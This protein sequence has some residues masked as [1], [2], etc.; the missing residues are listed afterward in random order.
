MKPVDLVVDVEARLP[1]RVIALLSKLAAAAIL[2]TA[3]VIAASPASAETRIV[4]IQQMSTDRYVDAH[5]HAGEDYR[6]VTREAQ[7]NDTQLW[8]M[9][10]LDGNVFTI[11]QLSSGRYWDAHEYDGQDYR[12]VTRPAQNNDTQRWLALDLGADIFTIQ[13]VSN[14]RYV[15]AH[16]NTA[17]DYRL[18]TR[19]AQ[20]NATQ[21][22]RITTILIEMV[23]PL[24]LPP[25]PPPTPA[26][27]SSGT[28]QLAGPFMMDLDTGGVSL[29]NGDILYAAPDLV[30]RQLV[31]RAGA[32]LSYLNGA[33]RGI[34]GFTG[35]CSTA[36]YSSNPVLMNMLSP[37]DYICAKT[38]E[39]RISE[40]RI[41]SIGPVLG[42]LMITYTTWQ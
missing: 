29:L 33:Q 32:Q 39:G 41:D 9:T 5:E 19:T 36:I 4:T 34:G 3:T 15:D 22:W 24:P 35:G 25:P 1:R 14:G 26:A 42:V 7:N 16:V 31:P 23:D 27:H 30:N 10:R 18:V 2:S 6:I 28:L 11:Q 17:E 40:F 21:Q 38:D 8:R 20:N 12:L 37:G 13:Q